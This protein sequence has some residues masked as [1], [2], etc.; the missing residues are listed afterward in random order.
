MDP[1]AV[2]TRTYKKGPCWIVE[3]RVNKGKGWLNASFVV[4]APDVEAMT[5]AEFEAFSRRKLPEVAEDI[6]WSKAYQEALV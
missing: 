1:I 6:D 3:G 2:I 4:H 5:R